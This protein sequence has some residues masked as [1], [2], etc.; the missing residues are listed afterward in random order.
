VKK[1]YQKN[2]AQHRLRRV[3]NIHRPTHSS[4]VTNW[5]NRTMALRW[6]AAGRI[7]AGKQFRRVNGQLHLPALRAALDAQGAAQTVGTVMMNP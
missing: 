2:A 3:D 1:T 7:K 4:K 5:Q 6:C